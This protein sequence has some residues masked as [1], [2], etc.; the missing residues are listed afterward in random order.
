MPCIPLVV[1]VLFVLSILQGCAVGPAE[2]AVA[3]GGRGACC[4]VVP[5]DHGAGVDHAATELQRYLASISGARLPIVVDGDAR[6]GPA[7]LLGACEAARA[8]GLVE[9]V[10]DL[11]EDGVLLKTVGR[12]LVILGGGERGQLFAVY[13]LL[14]RWL[15][16]RFLARDCV[17]TPARDELVLPV[18]DHR[19]APP[20]RYRE[21]LCYDSSDW[22]YAARLRLN[23]DDINQCL[24]RPNAEGVRIP[25]VLICPFAH[26]AEA[27]LPAGINFPAHPEYYGL[28]GGQRHGAAI[29]GQLCYTNPEVLRLCTDWVLR[30]LEQH[31]E[32]SCVDVSQND[33]YPG[34]SGACECDACRAVVEEEGAQHGPILRFVDAIADAVAKRFPDKLLGTLAYQH[35]VSTP[36]I[37]RPRDNVVIRLCQ[38]ACYF[39]GID[40]AP[41]GAIYRKALDD[42]RAVAPRIWVWHYGVNFWHYL[43]PNP[44]LA[45][46]ASDLKQYAKLGIDG[47]M[48]QCDIQSPGGE[49]AELR[50]YLCAQ[51]M[52]D[53]TR[54]P[55][56]IRRD[57]CAGY[58]GNAA[59]DVLA[60]LDQMDRWGA[61]TPHHIPMNGW[62]PPD[63]TQPE[64][65]AAAVETLGR[66]FDAAGDDLHRNRVEK[67]LLP[68]W[69]LQLSWPERYGI[70]RESGARL[71]PRVKRVIEANGITTISEG[72]PNAAA[73]LA[74]VSAR[75]GS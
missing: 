4:I 63:V 25:G 13:E 6:T 52:W 2:I 41:L 71:V 15:G 45:A 73:F 66:A 67:L 44:N 23:G 11:G 70:T 54:D 7:L 1:L 22:D 3:R 61:S 26:S 57:F 56:Q 10:R 53:P 35:T 27:M 42:W 16:C 38:H 37:T 36:K 39:H 29:G 5:R 72:P 48:V 55:M 20:F 30:W 19:Y 12:D 74:G 34:Q 43:A 32:V 24:G 8:T 46:L 65:V 69:Y 28:V 9:T 51:L 75:F 40:C 14:E 58:Y 49:L 60:F 18:I 68:F 62:H 50:S 47:V 33:A 64:I 17:I 31:P 21:I 59:D